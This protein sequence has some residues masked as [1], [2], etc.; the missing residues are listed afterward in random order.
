M[1]L[2]TPDEILEFW[3]GAAAHD[4]EAA[5]AQGKVWFGKSE[6]VDRDIE[7]RFLPTLERLASGAA[8]DWAGRGPRAL[9]AAIIVLDQ[10]SR[11]IFRGTP[12]AFEQDRL[13]LGLTKDG[14]LRHADEEL[15][16]VEQV[17]FYLPLEHSERLADQSLCVT[18]MEKLAASARP[19]FKPFADGTLDYARRHM[20]VIERFGRFPHRNDILGRVSTPEEIA[21]LAEPGSRF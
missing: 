4:G 2:A 19:D 14:L 21:F 12:R 1:R 8:F 5:R 13:A 7:A 10:F 9:L 18:L 16:E 20:A 11:N 17:F 6:A 3:I 15:T